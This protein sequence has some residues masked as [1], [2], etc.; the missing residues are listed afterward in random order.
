MSDKNHCHKF[1][2]QLTHYSWLENQNTFHQNTNT[3]NVKIF[4]MPSHFH[5]KFTLLQYSAT[6]EF[7][8]PLWKLNLE[9]W[10]DWDATLKISNY[11]MFHFCVYIL[12]L[13]QRKSE[14]PN[15]MVHQNSRKLVPFGSSLK[16]ISKLISST[17]KKSFSLYVC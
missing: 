2:T 4:L 12:L 14:K 7:L 15:Q 10:H 16:L 6:A 9:G 1:V 5:E 3:V 17:E 8:F 13:S 11:R